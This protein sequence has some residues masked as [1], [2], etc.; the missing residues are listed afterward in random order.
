[1]PPAFLE[2]LL[3]ELWLHIV[4]HIASPIGKPRERRLCK[5]DSD[6]SNTDNN[7]ATISWNGEVSVE[8]PSPRPCP[9]AVTYRRHIQCDFMLCQVRE[10]Y[11][12][13]A[14]AP[15]RSPLPVRHHI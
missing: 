12:R 14:T 1:M 2:S 9:R 7:Y 4:R 6:S 5:P 10:L 13:A 8:M 11:A 3:T 15:K